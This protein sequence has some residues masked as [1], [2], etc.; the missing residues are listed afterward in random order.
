MDDHLSVSRG[1]MNSR[2]EQHW[3][4]DVY[5]CA[6]FV[7]FPIGNTAE[8]VYLVL[9]GS[10]V[11]ISPQDLAALASCRE[12]RT[13][14]EHATALGLS[15]GPYGSSNAAMDRLQALARHGALISRHDILE[16]CG[17]ASQTGHGRDVSWL[18]VPTRNRPLQLER[19]LTSYRMS[20]NRYGRKVGYVIADDSRNAEEALVCS[21]TV[22]RFA[23][24]GDDPVYYMGA[25][26][27][28]KLA[29]HVAR[30]A[31]LPVDVVSFGLLGSGFHGTTTGSARNSL[32][33]QTVGELVLSFDDDTLCRAATVS[34]IIPG[35]DGLCLS[36][37]VDFSEMWFF[38]DRSDAFNSVVYHDVDL[39]AQHST[40]LGTP[41][42]EAV[43]SLKD[44]AKL[45][46]SD[47]CGHMLLALWGKCGRIR[48]TYTGL[49]GDSAAYSSRNLMALSN[50]NTRNRLLHTERN[51]HLTLRSR[52]V[53][54]HSLSRTI[55]HGLASNTVTVGLDN[56]SLLPPFIP[57]YWNEDGVFA[58]TITHVFDQVYFGH[59]PYAVPHDPP[60][61]T[62]QWRDWHPGASDEQSS[63]DIRV[64]D[65]IMGF[66]RMWSPT[67][68]RKE[69]DARLTSLARH[70]LELGS[71]RP[72]DFE[73]AM[74][75]ALWT[76]AGEHI[77][78]VEHLLSLHKGEPRFW[79]EHVMHHI[80][81]YIE[82]LAARGPIEL[83]DLGKHYPSDHILLV[84][85]RYVKSYGE[86]LYWWPAIVAEA[87]ALR[88]D[89]FPIAS[90]V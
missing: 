41:L 73:E 33:L 31:D 81:S 90:T 19:A 65:V 46:L 71:L 67:F 75:A 1:R 84:L 85:Q 42:S 57:V 34:S 12:F 4:Q 49:V 79:A 15:S 60:S 36:G 86:L 77:R 30:R 62:L 26:E 17:T 11:T 83:V 64:C 18:A 56:Q 25:A 32:L 28:R 45:D 5:R 51:Y 78:N 76:S 14:K 50:H 52:E 63:Y 22:A 68:K 47:T 10:G 44:P 82:I 9:L 74:R 7:R 23:A 6:P 66:T 35:S 89:G 16:R 37:H 69:D 29:E 21:Q 48:A 20:C 70:F 24:G 59:L 13:L 43:A 61:S 3:N 54:R 88:N 8:V 58:L 55:S 39:I 53:A 2:Q 80:E 40:L 87:T 38:P 27:R 72:A